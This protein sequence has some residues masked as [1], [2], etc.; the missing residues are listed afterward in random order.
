MSTV[1]ESNP[2]WPMTSAANEL[3]IDS[4]PLTTASPRAQIFFT[5]FSLTTLSCPF[6]EGGSACTASVQA[7]PPSRLPRLSRELRTAH[8][9]EV[10]PLADPQVL[11]LLEVRNRPD[12]GGG[13]HE[14]RLHRADRKAE[15]L[16][17]GRAPL[18]APV[19]LRHL[20]FA[21]VRLEEVDLGGGHAEHLGGVE[22][23]AAELERGAVRR[24]APRLPVHERELAVV[25]PEPEVRRHPHRCALEVEDLG[26]VLD[27]PVLGCTPANRRQEREAKKVAQTDRDVAGECLPHLGLQLD[28][29]F[30][31]EERHR[32]WTLSIASWTTRPAHCCLD[33][34]CLRM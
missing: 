5:V 8:D 30:V 19:E 33:A 28:R 27:R 34:S 17:D 23:V 31:L 9:P 29:V 18:V 7:P 26:P 11:G 4:H 12:I 10:T 14:V 3:G 20:R 6:G 13:T 1:S 16:L 25:R 15:L 22:R 2:W 24:R 21:Q 32:L